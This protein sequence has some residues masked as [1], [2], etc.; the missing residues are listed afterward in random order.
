MNNICR[1][2]KF[3]CERRDVTMSSPERVQ[4]TSSAAT[5]ERNVLETLIAQVQEL[6]TDNTS[7][8]EQLMVQRQ[9]IIQQS[10]DNAQTVSSYS[11]YLSLIDM[12]VIPNYLKGACC[13][14]KQFF[15]FLV[16]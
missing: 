8:K 11:H 4:D 15:C 2:N 6:K 9:Q 14:M 5:Q 12:K 3:H 13:K 7:L 1:Y 10:Y 16:I